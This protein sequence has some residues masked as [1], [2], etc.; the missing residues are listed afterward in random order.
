MITPTIVFTVVAAMAG[1]IISVGFAEPAAARN[2]I[3]VAEINCTLLVLITR[4]VH[5]ASVAVP[6][7]DEIFAPLRQEV[8]ASGVTD[9]ELDVLLRQARE[10]SWQAKQGLV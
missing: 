7:F 2:P 5:M 3:T 10:E 1:P 4:N 8:E 6:S 9:D